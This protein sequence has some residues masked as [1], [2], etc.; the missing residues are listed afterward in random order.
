MGDGW[1]GIPAD[2]FVQILLLIPPSPRRRLRLVCRH[3]RDAIDERAPEPRTRAKVL[4]FFH[5][6]QSS[7]AHVFDELLPGERGGGGRELDL[8][9]SGADYAGVC[10]VG[11]CNGLLLLCLYSYGGEI[12]VVNPAIREAPRV[13]PPA[14][15]KGWPLPRISD[16]HESTYSF[17][18]H[19]ATGQYKI[20]HVPCD[21]HAKLDAVHVFTL[22][23]DGPASREWREVPAPAGSSCRLRS[24]LVSIDGDTYWATKDADRVMSLDLKDE[25]FDLLEWPPLAGG[26][27]R[28]TDVHGRLGLVAVWSRDE[29]NRSRTEVWVLEGGREEERAWVKRYTL[30]AHGGRERQDIALPLVAHGEHVLTTSWCSGWWKARASL[31]LHA[32]KPRQER[33]LGRGV[34]RVGA[35]RLWTL[36]GE[37]ESLNLRTFAYVETREP[38]VVY[39]GHSFENGE[40]SREELLA[41]DGEDNEWS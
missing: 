36:V 9:G 12:A 27:C 28:L 24:G 30:L 16:L 15:G 21:R 13:A 17:A 31:S 7:R 37:Y 35:P 10:M 19:P 2:V 8:R 18:Y 34:L 29:P 33:K 38:V 22:G 23:I 26:T 25:R 5:E 6:D 40:T 32:R 20:V 39:G 41:D 14:T 1:D 11:T 3:W 4:A